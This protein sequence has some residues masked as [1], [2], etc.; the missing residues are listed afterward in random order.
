M[1]QL[2]LQVESGCRKFPNAGL[3]WFGAL[4]GAIQPLSQERTSLHWDE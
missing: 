4:E 2:N 3:G 1:K